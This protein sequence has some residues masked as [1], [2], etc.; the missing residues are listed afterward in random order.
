MNV[1]SFYE[2]FSAYVNTYNLI[3]HIQDIKKFCFV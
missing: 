1:I 3:G 2:S